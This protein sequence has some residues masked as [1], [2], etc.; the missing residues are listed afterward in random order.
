MFRVSGT[1]F[2]L[3]VALVLGGCFEIHRT[4]QGAFTPSVVNLRAVGVAMTIGKGTAAIHSSRE[5]QATVMFQPRKRSPYIVAATPGRSYLS[6]DLEL[7]GIPRD[8][9]QAMEVLIYRFP[10]TQDM[11]MVL[12]YQD[13]HVSSTT[14]H[15]NHVTVPEL[16]TARSNG[17]PLRIEVERAEEGRA[18]LV[19]MEAS[20]GP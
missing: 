19:A 10:S 17:G 20:G 14:S 1:V 11:S 18:K 16:L 2:T 7:A 13:G 6:G 8:V 12:F 15:L 5:N 3:S 9:A 4:P